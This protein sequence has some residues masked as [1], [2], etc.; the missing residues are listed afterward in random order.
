MPS[1]DKKTVCPSRHSSLL[2]HFNGLE[3]VVVLN[4]LLWIAVILLVFAIL[5]I[6]YVCLLLRSVAAALDEWEAQEGHNDIL[7]GEPT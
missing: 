5:A 3:V 4:I 2:Q 7:D 6:T 1:C